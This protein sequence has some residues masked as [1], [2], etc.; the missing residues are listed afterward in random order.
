MPVIDR[1]AKLPLES[2][3][4]RVAGCLDAV[5]AKMSLAHVRVTTDEFDRLY[6]HLASHKPKHRN[7]HLREA[8][9]RDGQR[10]LRYLHCIYA[11]LGSTQVVEG[12]ISGPG[13]LWHYQLIRSRARTQLNLLEENAP[14][15]ALQRIGRRFLPEILNRID[16]EQSGEIHFP[17]RKPGQFYLRRWIPGTSVT[18][19]HCQRAVDAGVLAPLFLSK[20]SAW[21]FELLAP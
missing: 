17:K 7:M 21:N 5:R 14:R 3:S 20:L 16:T 19:R 13:L 2:T 1:R 9:E 4:N 8:C 12:V 11:H 15:R 6:G 10:D 18:H